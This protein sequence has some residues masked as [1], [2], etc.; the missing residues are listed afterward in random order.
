MSVVYIPPVTAART[1]TP[2]AGRG[3]AAGEDTEEQG[4]ERQAGASGTWGAPRCSK[5]LQTVSPFCLNGFTALWPP[6]RKPKP[7]EV[8]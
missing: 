7:R 5:L 2:G 6:R 4:P 3:R 8:L 1:D